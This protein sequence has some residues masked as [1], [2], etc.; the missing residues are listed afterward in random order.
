[1]EFD[2]G[3]DFL[4]GHILNNSLKHTPD[5][6]AVICHGDS[7]TYRELDRN[8]NRAA[9]AVL[10]MVKTGD[11]IG[12]ISFNCIDYIELMLGCARAGVVVVHIN[13]RLSPG[14]IW[15]L[16]RFNDCRAAFIQTDQDAWEQ[17]LFR[18]ADRAFPFISLKKRDGRSCYDDLIQNETDEFTE[19]LISPDDV[20]MH[21]HTSGT[22]GIPKCVMHTH[23]GFVSEMICCRDEMGFSE[24][25]VFQVV[26]QLFHVASIGSY[27]ELFAGGTLVLFRGFNADE[28]LTSVEE[29]H[30]TRLSVIPTVLKWILQQLKVREYCLESLKTV[31]YSACPIPPS[32]MDEAIARLHCQFLQSYGMTEMGSVV[33]ILKPKDHWSPSHIR[34]VGT[35]IPGCRIRIEDENGCD[36]GIGVTGEIT[37]SGPSMLAGYYK[38]PE[39]YGEHVKNGWF[40]TGDLGYVDDE[41]YLYLEGRKKDMIISG[42]ENIYPKEIEDCLMELTDDIAE[43]AVFGIEDETWGESPYACVVLQKESRLTAGEI[44]AYLRNHLAHY[45]VPKRIELVEGLPKNT[46]G[47]VM[48]HELQNRYRK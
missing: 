4:F 41:G 22:T 18:L 15:N 1:M 6:K 24:S 25:E 48:K 45:K 7:V 46:V 34:S 12:I 20:L 8:A 47:K 31:S 28:Y 26:S 2:S 3:T 36:A 29:N 32:V 35:C 33:T 27:M 37:V 30:V 16:L 11:K 23:R 40:H 17:E 10:R 19:P 9:N 5:K 44:R 14:E 42:G 21:I 38:R 39:L 13:W 43:A